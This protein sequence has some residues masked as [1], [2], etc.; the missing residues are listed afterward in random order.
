MTVTVTNR[1]GLRLPHAGLA[2]SGLCS[3][4]ACS[5]DRSSHV[6]HSLGIISRTGIALASTK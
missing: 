5:I 1:V 4:M 6:S 2:A 3:A